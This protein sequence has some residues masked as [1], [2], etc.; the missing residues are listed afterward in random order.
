MKLKQILNKY[1]PKSALILLICAFLCSVIQIFAVISEDFADF[2]NQTVAAFF[3]FIL[4]KITGWIPFSLTEI[5]IICLPIIIGIIILLILKRAKQGK[6]AVIRFLAM[7][8][9][10]MSLFYSSFVLTFAC[11]YRGVPLENKLRLEKTAVSKD[12]LDYTARIVL[13]ELNT[14]AEQ[15]KYGEDNFSVMPYSFDELNE[16]LNEAYIRGAEKYPFIQSM[17]SNVKPIILSDPMTYTHITG[18]YT[19]FSGEAN[20]NTNYKDFNLPFTMAHEM[21][22]QRGIARENEANFVAYLICLES[23]DKYIKYSA[24][25]NMFEYL[26]NALYK[27]DREMYKALFKSLDANVYNELVA[28]SEYYDKYRDSVAADISGAINNSYLQSQGQT[29]GT[30]SYGLVVDLAVA[31]YKGVNQ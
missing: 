3:R 31:Y 2:F 5:T 19:Y 9:A 28:Y 26:S 22:H 21:A 6:T 16:K 24:Y 14:L 1:L 11:G 25:L 18:V 10:V 23:D 8:L 17:R 20:V 27:S 15:T 29:A 7:F 12:E 30:K 13:R 4:T